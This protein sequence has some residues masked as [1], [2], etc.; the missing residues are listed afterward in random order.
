MDVDRRR[1]RE[2]DKLIRRVLAVDVRRHGAFQLHP[3]RVALTAL[4]R[5]LARRRGL[6]T[7]GPVSV[8]CEMR[9]T[10]LAMF[11]S[12][13]RFDGVL[14][15]LVSGTIG[16]SPKGTIVH[17]RYHRATSGKGI[18]VSID[19]RKA[20]VTRRG[21]G[22]VFSGFCHMPANGLRGMGKC[23]LKLCCMGAVVRGRNKAIYMGDRP[24][25]NDAFAVAL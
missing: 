12:Q 5:S 21:R 25:R 2:L 13:A 4:L 18:R 16:C 14:D 20:N 23:K 8:S 7:R 24:K 9:P 22:R 10:G 15:G 19:S 6:G 11:T 3:R 1:L 17:V